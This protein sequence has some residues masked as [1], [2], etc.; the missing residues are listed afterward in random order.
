MGKV[1]LFLKRTS[2]VLA[3]RLG[4]VFRWLVR[5]DRF[6]PCWRQANVTPIS[7]GP[8]STS[9]D[10]DRPIS[11]TSVLSKVFERLVSVRL[12]RFKEGSGVL[13]I[14]QF[15]YRKSVGIS[16]AHFCV[17]HT[18]QSALES[19][20]ETRIVQ[21]DFRAAL[22]RVKPQGILYKLCY[23]CIGGSLLS[24]L[25]QFLPNQSQHVMADICRAG[26]VF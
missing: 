21:I 19:G 2:D 24:V 1:P 14:T 20:K 18:P 12:G 5:L 16:D 25:T 4:V 26:A 9:V 8:P 11:I 22:D 17:S 23:M 15:A 3:P 10:N 6:P 7:K 13:P